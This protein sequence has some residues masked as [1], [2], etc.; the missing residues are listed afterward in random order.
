MSNIDSRRCA[1]TIHGLST[2]FAVTPQRIA[3]P[4][5]PTRTAPAQVSW[6]RR[7]GRRSSTSAAL[8][9]ASPPTTLISVRLPNS[10][11]PWT[12]SAGVGTREVSSHRG[13]VGQ[14]IPEP[15]RRTTP[16]VITM[17]TLAAREASA[18]RRSSADEARKVRSRYTPSWYG[19]D[20][21]DVLRVP[22][23]GGLDHRRG[24][25]QFFEEKIE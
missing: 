9:S 25:C 17:P 21:S 4:T 6:S 8:A 19:R 2:V 14:P 12:P 1:D 10:M 22:L 13:Q 11:S 16:P 7:H 23:H 24:G 20:G 5:T 15:V 3:W 18:V